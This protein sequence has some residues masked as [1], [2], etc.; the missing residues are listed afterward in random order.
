MTNARRWRGRLCVDLGLT[1]PFTFVRTNIDLDT[2]KYCEKV[3]QANFSEIRAF[4]G[5]S[6]KF[7]LK[8]NLFDNS[9]FFVV[10]SWRLLFWSARTV[11]KKFAVCGYM[12]RT[13][14]RLFVLH[15]S[16]KCILKRRFA[17]FHAKFTVI[18]IR[19]ILIDVVFWRPETQ[20]RLLAAVRERSSRREQKIGPTWNTVRTCL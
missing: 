17:K 20:A 14:K 6:T 12:S 11:T 3:M 2:C 7:H 10:F 19:I 9:R 8:R 16:S 13:F 1:K 15:E 18:W 5:F 4:C